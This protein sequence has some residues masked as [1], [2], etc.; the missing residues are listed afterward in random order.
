M[1]DKNAGIYSLDSPPPSMEDPLATL[2]YREIAHR[3]YEDIDSVKVSIR[4]T[5]SGDDAVVKLDD[6]PQKTDL[7]VWLRY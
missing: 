2:L 5:G 6:A 7:K 1:Y 4:S 3:V